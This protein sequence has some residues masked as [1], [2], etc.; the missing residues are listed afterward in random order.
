MKRIIGCMIALTLV[1]LSNEN[2][3]SAWMYDYYIGKKF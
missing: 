2:A 1:S 3:V